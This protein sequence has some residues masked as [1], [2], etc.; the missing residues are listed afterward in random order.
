MPIIAYK[1]VTINIHYAQGRRIDCEHCH[2]PFTYITDGDESA[3]STGLPLVSSDEGMGK[4]AMKGLSK[5]LASVAGKKNTGHGIC[6]HCSQYQGW[7]VRNSLTKNIGCCS[8]GIAFV[9][10]LVPVIINIFKD[11]LDMGMWILGAAILGFILGIGLG[12]LTALKGGVQRELDEDETIL[13]MDDEFL[14][15]HLDA[16]GENDYD[17]ILTW[18]LMTGFEPSDDAPLISLGF[19]DYSKQQIIPYEISSVAALEE[20]G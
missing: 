6:P 4:S 2:Q 1:T 10:A 18:L 5:S 7:M 14:Q 16:C 19:N 15:A 3:Q 20:L 17:P 13:S 9:F 8:F 11:H 12:F